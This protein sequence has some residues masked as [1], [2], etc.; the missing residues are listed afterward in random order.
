M[1]LVTQLCLTLCTPMDCRP[2]GSSVHAAS[3]GKN[4]RVGCHDLLQGIFLTQ[5]LNPGLLHCRWILYC[6][7]HQGSFLLRDLGT[8]KMHLLRAFQVG[9]KFQRHWGSHH[10]PCVPLDRGELSLSRE[11]SQKEL[12]PRAGAAPPAARGSVPRI[13]L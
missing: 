10:P 2:P 6:L 13:D 8:T 11:K 5:Q 9:E 1:C 4:T 12:T 7:S 3:P